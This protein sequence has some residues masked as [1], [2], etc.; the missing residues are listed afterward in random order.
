[1][2]AEPRLRPDAATFSRALFGCCAPEPIRLVDGAADPPAPALTHRF[3]RA[4]V[5]A[6]PAV[7]TTG[8][9]AGPVS[10]RVR[11]LVAGW[12]RRVGV[13]GRLALRRSALLFAA[14]SLVALAVAGGVVWASRSSS[15]PI[16]TP[17]TAVTPVAA[18]NDGPPASSATSATSADGSPAPSTSTVSANPTD[19]ATVL[20]NL[21]QLR[22]RAFEDAASADLDLVYQPQAP[23]LATDRATLGRLVAAGEHAVGLQPRLIGVTRQSAP[24]AS[25]ASLAGP[26]TLVV[27]DT[28]PAYAI[29]NSTGT[30]VTVPGRGERRWLVVLSAAGSAAG[31]RIASITAA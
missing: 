14:G 27:E 10:G 1:M 2:V 19:W 23:A 16:A 3:D 21:D 20:A 29:V 6:R 4:A 17:S 7:T 15:T 18:G 26:V 31:W 12:G 13:A 25:G 30:S 11:R 9:S 28:L 8:R 24:E 5:V 22:D